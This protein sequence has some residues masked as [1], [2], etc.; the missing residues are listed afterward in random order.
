L[1]RPTTLERHEKAVQSLVADGVGIREIARRLNLPI[2]SAFK[3]V[4]KAQTT[5]LA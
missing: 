5:A 1:G 2:A 4:R 3:L